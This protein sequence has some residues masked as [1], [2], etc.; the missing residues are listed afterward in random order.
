LDGD[1]LIRMND[2]EAPPRPRASHRT[3]SSF[4]PR[5]TAIS[6][7]RTR[8]PARVRGND[9]VAGT[10]S[11]AMGASA[12]SVRPSCKH[13]P[14]N[15]PSRTPHTQGLLLPQTTTFGSGGGCSSSD[16][17]GGRSSSSSTSS[18]TS[19]STARL[20]CCASPGPNPAGPAAAAACS[21][22]LCSSRR[23]SRPEPKLAAVAATAAVPRPVLGC[24]RRN[25]TTTT[26]PRVFS[27]CSGSHKDRSHTL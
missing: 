9:G 21:S 5:T 8:H 7:Q 14:H 23:A 1:P 25:G 20:R 19:T 3:S 4:A 11:V 24:H 22:R 12:S 13:T 18:S 17:G 15:R 16:G 2:H 26:F 27:T 6:A 10:R